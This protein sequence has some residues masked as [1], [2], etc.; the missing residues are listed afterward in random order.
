M[1]EITF[2]N[3]YKQNYQD[4]GFCLYAMKNGLGGTLYVGISKVDIWERWFG[5]RGHVTW[6]ENYISGNSSVGE[7]IVDHIPDSLSWKIQLWTLNDC[8]EYCKEEAIKRNSHTIQDAERLMI[9]KLSPM[10]NRTYNLNPGIDT[11][12][13]SEKELKRERYADQ[14]YAEIFNKKK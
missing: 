14:A 3:F 2:W 1:I 4:N 13:K 6:D 8:L 10:L 9:R 12:P 5:G 7:K 11:T